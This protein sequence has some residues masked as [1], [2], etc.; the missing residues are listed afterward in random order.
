M[1]RTARKYVQDSLV[2]T[3]KL[4]KEEQIRR[5][6]DPAYRDSEDAHDREIFDRSMENLERRAA[7]ERDQ[8]LEIRSRHLRFVNSQ[9]WRQWTETS[10]VTGAGYVTERRGMP[11]SSRDLPERLVHV[12]HYTA[13]DS[14]RTTGLDPNRV[15]SGTGLNAAA[16]DKKYFIRDG[17]LR[18]TY[19][20]TSSHEGT[21]MDERAREGGRVVLIIHTSRQ[22]R[23][24]HMRTSFAA[25][26]GGPIDEQRPSDTVLSF[27]RISPDWIS[28]VDPDTGRERRLTDFPSSYD[29]RRVATRPRNGSQL[30]SREEIA[31]RRERVLATNTEENRKLAE[32]RI[33]EEAERQ[34]QLRAQREEASRRATSSFIDNLARCIPKPPDSDS[35]EDEDEDEDT[36]K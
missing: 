28:I 21:V 26:V 24:A 19:L 12:T 33:Q 36:W 1:E 17:A 4:P 14:I 10:G 30:L 2:N 5:A 15:N 7:R 3:G 22:F 18:S 31:E 6:A 27:Q 34:R 20:A 32:Q 13:L 29:W 8:V 16:A 11:P 25:G 9:P 23:Q 35:D